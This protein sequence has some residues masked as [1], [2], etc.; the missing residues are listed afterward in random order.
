MNRADTAAILNIDPAASPEQT[1]RAYQEL[2]TTHQFW[3]T[4]APTPRRKSLYQGRLRELDEARD[5]LLVQ[6]PTDATLDLPTDQPSLPPRSGEGQSGPVGATLRQ[7]PPE[8]SPAGKQ[9]KS[10]PPEKAAVVEAV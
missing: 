5:I 6:E 8:S 2:F 9:K 3:L 10:T 1:R 4:N 7:P